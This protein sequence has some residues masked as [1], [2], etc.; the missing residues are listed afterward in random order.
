MTNTSLT[1]TTASSRTDGGNQTVEHSCTDLLL[2][3]VWLKD[4]QK[5]LKGYLRRLC[6]VNN[7]SVLSISHKFADRRKDHLHITYLE[8]I[9]DESL[10]S[11]TA[12]YFYNSV[13]ETQAAHF[14][15][16]EIAYYIERRVPFRRIKQL[17]LQELQTSYIEGVRVICSG[18]VGVDLKKL[19]VHVGKDFNGVKL[20]H[21]FFRLNYPLPLEAP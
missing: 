15:S 12:L 11:P 16:D 17:L 4:R 1:A 14:V 7:S 10:S 18:R 13:H 2:P 3:E 19:N 6:A 21:T 20:H 9:L 5:Q 8:S